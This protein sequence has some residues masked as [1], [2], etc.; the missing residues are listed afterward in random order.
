[1]Y[2]RICPCGKPADNPRGVPRCAECVLERRRRWARDYKA[3]ESKDH[4]KRKDLPFSGDRLTAVCRWCE[5]EFA[6]VYVN[7]LRVK[8]DEC[9]KRSGTA[10]RVAWAKNNPD[11]IRELKSR[12]NA[13]LSGQAANAEQ[14]RKYRFRKYGVDEAWFDATLAAQGG[15]CAICHAGEPG[16]RHGT[17]NIDHDRSCCEAVP[18]CGQCVRGILCQNCNQGL[19]MFGDD[20]ER[21]QWAIVYLKE[22]HA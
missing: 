15:G 6:Y 13:T 19:G 5:I 22:N 4:R 16:G 11:R 7:Q 14:A 20:P 8:C 9:K 1:M 10:L 17:W 12:Y 3:R 21:L 2:E 18:C